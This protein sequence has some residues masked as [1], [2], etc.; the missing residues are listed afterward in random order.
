[1]VTLGQQKDK[2]VGGQMIGTTRLVVSQVEIRESPNSM[3]VQF[4]W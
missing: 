1:V 4:Y 3:K 2:A